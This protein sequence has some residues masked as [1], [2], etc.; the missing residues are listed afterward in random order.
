M[1]SISQ[2]AQ[3]MPP[4][5]IRK[6][7]PYADAAKAKGVH[8]FHLNIGQPDVLPPD[9][10]WD[11]IKAHSKE[12]WLIVIAQ[13]SQSSATRQPK[14]TEMGIP[15]SPEEVLVTTAGSNRFP[16]RCRYCAIRAMK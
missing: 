10:F 4:S 3:S 6:L 16:S 15:V 9:Q 1:P 2:R 5:P 13:E 14:Y 12:C 11:S 8:I 7:A